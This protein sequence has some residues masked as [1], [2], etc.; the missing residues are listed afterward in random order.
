MS[1]I[2]DVVITRKHLLLS[3]KN[4]SILLS[5]VI[6]L[7]LFSPGALA[8]S[9]A[10]FVGYTATT[11]A[12]SIP[13]GSSESDVAQVLATPPS[14]GFRT[15][16]M[17]YRAVVFA[18]GGSANTTLTVLFPGPGESSPA[19]SIPAKRTVA[20]LFETMVPVNYPGTPITASM[21]LIAGSGGGLTVQPST[22]LTLEGV[23]AYRA[24]REVVTKSRW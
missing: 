15:A 10:G 9:P 7:L 23:P 16:M 6:T 2:A 4:T 22:S 13:A 17:A 11:S 24:E 8:Q 5:S 18:T 14:D 12:L 20:L 1:E 21:T 3:Y 19:V